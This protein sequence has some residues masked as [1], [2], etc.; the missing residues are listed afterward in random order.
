MALVVGLHF[1]PIA[2]AAGF[3]PFYVLG[4]SLVA[5]AAAAFAVGG[6]AGGTLAGFTAA[7]ALWI[8]STFAVLRDRDAKRASL[9]RD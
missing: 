6:S 3:R 9:P 1:L 8:A 2:F 7:G 4:A 5:T